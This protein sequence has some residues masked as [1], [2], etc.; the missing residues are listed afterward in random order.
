VSYPTAR[1]E[2]A[3]TRPGDFS[4]RGVVLSWAEFIKWLNGE[5]QGAAVDGRP[6]RLP[7]PWN[8][9]QHWAL[10]GK[11]REGKSN[12]AIAVLRETRKY[13]L[14]LDPK[15]EDETLTKSGWLR[16]TSLPNAKRSLGWKLSHQEEAKL[17]RGIEKDIEEGRPARLIVGLDSR[18]REDD[19]A[20]KRLMRDAVEYVRESRGW[21]MYV[22]EHQIATDPR[23]FG[24]GPQVARASISAA[25]SKTSVITTMQYLSWSE[26]APIRQASFITI[27]KTK[28]RDLVKKLSEEIGRDWRQL[29]SIVDELNKYDCATFSDD[30]RSPVIV[31]RP[32]KV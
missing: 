9:G 7:P 10:I 24:L 8:P 21:S 31:T 12:F 14:A 17:W 20:N 29:A 4:D 27:W 32:P 19:E 6:V 15:G 26:K 13:V 30:L 25:R 22:D 3:A 18:T 16:V 28:S 1:A 2:P 5:K 11:T 23:M